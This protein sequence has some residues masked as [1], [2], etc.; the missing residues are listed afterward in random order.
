MLR[1]SARLCVVDLWDTPLSEQMPFLHYWKHVD[2]KTGANYAMAI[3]RSVN[4]SVEVIQPRT[5][6]RIRWYPY[7]N[8]YFVNDKQVP[9]F[10]DVLQKYYFPPMLN[11]DE[12]IHYIAEKTGRKPIDIAA[13]MF[14]MRRLRLGVCQSLRDKIKGKWFRKPVASWTPLEKTYLD[15]SLKV[16]QVFGADFY[17]NQNFDPTLVYSPTYGFADTVDMIF[18]KQIRTKQQYLLVEVVLHNTVPKARFPGTRGNVKEPIS[19]YEPCLFSMIKMKLQVMAHIVKEEDY[20]TDH[21]WDTGHSYQGAIV[22]MHKGTEPG[23]VMHNIE[24]VELDLTEGR[25]WLN[26]FREHYYAKTGL[27][28]EERQDY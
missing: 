3:P 27:A 15:Q 19:H 24:L 17:S 10:F 22:H 20:V 12:R 5:A 16:A 14:K 7:R 25:L 23:E 21:A 13:E 4:G 2:G 8:E 11:D 1:R 26:H 9:M 18:N 28:R 6:E